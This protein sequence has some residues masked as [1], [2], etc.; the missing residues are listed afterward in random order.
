MTRKARMSGARIA[1]LGAAR[2]SDRVL[3]G[4]PSRRDILRRERPPLCVCHTPPLSV[5]HF[6]HPR[7]RGGSP[8][9]RLSA[10]SAR[11]R[12]RASSR[13]AHAPRRLTERQRWSTT[14]G[15]RRHPVARRSNG[16][17]IGPRPR[18]R[19]LL[20]PHQPA[21]IEKMMMYASTTASETNRTSSKTVI[22]A[23]GGESL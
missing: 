12:R 17:T 14:C 3:A 20:E 9:A 15:P 16:S 19:H 23:A 10:S 13:C 6:A 7:P 8:R 2:R 22:L 1:P 18:R 21:G 11:R 5:W 4:E